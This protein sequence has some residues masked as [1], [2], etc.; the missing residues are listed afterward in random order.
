MSLSYL[1][2]SEDTDHIIE[3]IAQVMAKGNGA[4][5]LLAQKGGQKTAV[6]VETGK[7]DIKANLDKIKNAGFDRI[8]FV[9]TSAAA[10]SAC[11]KAIDSIEDINRA[12]IEQLT[13]LDIS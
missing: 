5:D 13:W 3:H 7:S 4:I 6:E 1:E 12:I 10:V 8:I 9:A 11:H 2:A